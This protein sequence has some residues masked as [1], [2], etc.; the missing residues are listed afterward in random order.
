MFD[1]IEILEG[2]SISQEIFETDY[3]QQIRLLG[4]NLVNWENDIFSAP[5]EFLAHEDHNLVF[6]HKAADNINYEEAFQRASQ[7][8]SSD[9]DQFT[10]LSREIP[11]FGPE[12]EF[13]KIYINGIME[14]V[15]AHH[16]W[17]MASPRYNSCL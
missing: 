16:F 2:I 3:F 8:L 1:F 10:R 17:A 4:A 11:D 13:V 5:K 7:D 15:A 6:V 9:L 12:T 14:W